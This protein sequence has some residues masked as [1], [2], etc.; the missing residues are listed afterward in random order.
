MSKKNDKIVSRIKNSSA[1]HDHI[2]FRQAAF[3]ETIKEIEEEA[4]NS[5][6]FND[7]EYLNWD[8]EDVHASYAMLPVTD[9]G[10]ENSGRFYLRSDYQ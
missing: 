1:Y 8:H 10:P 7:P 5:E 4:Q 2:K 9:I 6:Q 3:A